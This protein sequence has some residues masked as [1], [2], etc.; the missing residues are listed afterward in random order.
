MHAGQPAYVRCVSCLL[1]S[2]TTAASLFHPS[3][4]LSHAHGAVG[5]V[6][7]SVAEC[8]RHMV[9]HS[10]RLRPLHQSH[11]HLHVKQSQPAWF[12]CGTNSS[13][14]RAEACST[15]CRVRAHRPVHTAPSQELHP[16]RRW[17]GSCMHCI[18]ATTYDDAS[19]DP[20]LRRAWRG[21]TAVRDD[22]SWPRRRVPRGLS[23]PRHAVTGTIIN[24]H[25]SICLVTANR[26][27]MTSCGNA[28]LPLPTL[29]LPARGTRSRQS[30]KGVLT[31]TVGAGLQSSVP[32]ALHGGSSRDTSSSTWM[33]CCVAIR[34]KVS[35]RL[36]LPK[37]L[38]SPL[39]SRPRLRTGPR[40]W[41]SWALT[42]LSFW[43][44]Y[45]MP[46][47]RASW[48]RCICISSKSMPSSMCKASRRVRRAL[49]VTY[50]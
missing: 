48:G 26:A 25:I 35:R 43:P 49:R 27:A 1:S 40:C 17:P 41:R 24:F 50:R 29:L 30:H 7:L 47:V 32:A 9:Q 8:A 38:T 45:R 44:A 15:R 5:V 13:R 2:L 39:W 46:R 33:S 14:C 11:K 6:G 12:S 10:T 18:T 37:W 28:C 31:L 34:N 19:L 16:S 36:I 23:Q 21:H 20:D 4:P 42:A 3:L 22:I